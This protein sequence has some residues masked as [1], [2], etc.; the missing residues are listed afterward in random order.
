MVDAAERA[1]SLF[2][3][4]GRKKPGAEPLPYPIRLA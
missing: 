2:D 1:T 4:K 3:L